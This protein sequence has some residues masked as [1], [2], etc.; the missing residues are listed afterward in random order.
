ML[1]QRG[2]PLDIQL[3]P[4][5]EQFFLSTLLLNSEDLTMARFREVDT[6]AREHRITFGDALVHRGYMQLPEMLS[7]RESR[8]LF[9]LEQIFAVQQGTFTFFRLS[10]APYHDALPMIDL[11]DESFRALAERVEQLKT[12]ELERFWRIYQ[13]RYPVRVVPPV[14]D[15]HELPIDE[16]TRVFYDGVLSI[17]QPLWESLSITNL[18]RAQMMQ[19]ILVMEQ[20]GLVE[21]HTRLDPIM[22]VAGVMDTLREHKARL[23]HVNLF[24]RLG[25]H[26]SST[27]EEVEEG[28][29]IQKTRFAPEQLP[30]SVRGR[31]RDVNDAIHAL[32]DEAWELLS[33]AQGRARHRKAFVSPAAARRAIQIAL[34]R[35][36]IMAWAR[37]VEQARC[38]FQQVLELDP[39]NAQALEKLKAINAY[40]NQRS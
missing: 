18:S 16:S 9:M 40:M 35:G 10:E 30:P 19:V 13:K 22:R 15:I 11:L 5:P 17:E 8:L 21:F 3:T 4:N 14:V 29:A 31:A 23:E 20:L 33:T 7:A 1:L 36:D 27:G 25:V 32:L 28:Y 2:M 26:W 12:A 38:C 6:F 24:E 37:Q 34:N 39:S